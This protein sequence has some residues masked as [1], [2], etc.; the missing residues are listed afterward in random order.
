VPSQRLVTVPFVLV[1]MAVFLGALSPNLFV[2]ASRYLANAGYDPDE[3]GIV[4]SSFMVG[5]LST[6][7]WVGRIIQHGRRATVVVIGCLVGG[8]GCLLFEQ[9]STLPGFVAARIVQ[10]CGFACVL[11]SGSAY[12]AEIAP[13][14]RLAQALGFA[15]VLTLVA[16][17]AGPAFGEFIVEAAGWE[18][19]FWSGT[20]AGVVGAVV[21]AFLSP[22]PDREW[23]ASE[24]RDRVGA[25]AAIAAMA[26]AGFGFGAVVG[27][28]AAYADDAGVG[29]VNPF[30][31]AYVIAAVFT[32]L[33]L[34]HLADRHGRR[35]T[36]M[37]ALVVQ[38]VAF[39]LL[40]MVTESWHLAAIGGM[41][42][43]S[44]GVYYPSLQAQI[45]ERAPANARSRAVAASTLAFGGGVFT[46]ILGLGFVADA[47]GYSTIYL[48]AAGAGG[49]ATIA[50]WMD[51]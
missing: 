2:L 36:A 12:V 23:P 10:G 18:W 7:P 32:R 8:V 26:L 27:F 5:S 34:G 14:A 19:L 29:K 21:G 1:T 24:D 17:A 37:P 15:G 44:H 31:I 51:R 6:M 38:S 13:P 35:A 41:Y 22:I 46:A 28:I 33:G 25:R 49:A 16:Q 43:L 47:F 30:F 4:M 42:G 11:V 45:V 9:A 48:I 50:V 3:I 40:S 39:V 20:I